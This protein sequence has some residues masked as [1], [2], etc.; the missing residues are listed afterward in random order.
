MIAGSLGSIHR[1]GDRH[2]L[3]SHRLEM[4]TYSDQEHVATAPLS[5]PWYVGKERRLC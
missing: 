4:L 2:T 5:L 1:R 3:R